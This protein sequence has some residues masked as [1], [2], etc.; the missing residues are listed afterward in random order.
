V[1][2]LFLSF[3]LLAVA[4]FASLKTT[5]SLLACLAIVTLVVKVTASKFIGSVTLLDAARSVASSA[6]SLALAIAALLFVAGGQVQLEG[7]AAVA[8][9]ALLFAAFVFGFKVSL[10]ATFGASAAVAAV[11]TLVSGVL[12][13]LLKPYMF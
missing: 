9:L 3:A 11:S 13:F 5:L 1:P 6:V 7:A 12:L 4:A 8:L 2:Y 10:G